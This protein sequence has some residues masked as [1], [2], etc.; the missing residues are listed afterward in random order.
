MAL[1]ALALV[2]AC[3][4]AVAGYLAHARAGQAR[5]LASL[6]SELRRLADARPRPPAPEAQERGD[7]E[8]RAVS[9]EADADFLAALGHDIRT[10]L[11]GVLGMT[12]L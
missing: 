11:N 4:L 9:G 1:A 2:A 10:P 6:E 5:R 7:L 12:G 8:T 3:A